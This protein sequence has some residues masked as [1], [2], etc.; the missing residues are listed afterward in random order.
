M[1]EWA[2]QCSERDRG[3]LTISLYEITEGIAND[4]RDSIHIELDLRQMIQLFDAA[5]RCLA[6][7]LRVMG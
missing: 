1:K 2:F 7:H 5:F 6:Y 4:K 3:T